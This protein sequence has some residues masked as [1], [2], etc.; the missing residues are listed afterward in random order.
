MAPSPD[1]QKAPLRLVYSKPLM[2]L[3]FFMLYIYQGFL[4][5]I[6]ESFK[7]LLKERGLKDSALASFALTNSPFYLKFLA[8]PILDTCY[9]KKVGKRMTW[10]VPLSVLSSLGYFFFADQ[11]E[12]WL[13]GLEVSKLCFFL[14]AQFVFVAI[15]DVAIDGM[16]CEILNEEDFEK[17]TLMQTLGQTIGPFLCCNIYILLVS[18]KFGKDFFGLDS[19]VLTTKGFLHILGC[20]TLI[21]SFFAQQVVREKSSGKAIY[22][23]KDN[24]GKTSSAADLPEE[25]H[26][27]PSFLELLKLIPKMVFNSNIR[28]ILVF[29]ALFEIFIL[30]TDSLCFV[31]LME[32]G[33]DLVFITEFEIWFFVVDLIVIF[34]IGKLNVMQ[35][36]WKYYITCLDILFLNAILFWVFFFFVPL[37]THRWLWLGFLVFYKLVRY[38]STVKFT[39]A[40]VFV[41]KV[42][43]KSM[44]GSYVTIV[45]S[46]HNFIRINIPALALE[47]TSVFSLWSIVCLLAV[48]EGVYRYLKILTPLSGKKSASSRLSFRGKLVHYFQT[49]PEQAFKLVKKNTKIE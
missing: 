46:I 43:D 23:H 31:K 16:V 11:V 47:L 25:H 13:K 18:E 3:I 38:L 6:N 12:E 34:A 33:F 36:L 14:F 15:Q 41:Q 28:K 30:F 19:S 2:V 7:L 37:D 22:E 9:F 49:T 5:G 40:M 21:T 44:G 20:F 27:E 42:C 4:F 39:C 48:L 1:S 17:G 35:N 26:D 45:S 24:P 8:A 10:I 32:K 29:P